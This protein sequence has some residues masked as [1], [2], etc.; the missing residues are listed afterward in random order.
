MRPL[1]RRTIVLAPLAAVFASGC[2]DTDALD[3]LPE[4]REGRVTGARAGGVIELDGREPVKLAGLEAPDA[5]EPYAQASRLIL[6]RLTLNRRV[7]LYFAGARTDASGM[8]LAQVEDAD[9]RRWIQ[10]ALL[11]AGAARVRTEPDACAG[12]AAMLA[13]EARARSAGRGVWRIPMYEVRLPT[14]FGW[15]DRGFML[16]EGRV[17]RVGEGRD[18]LYLD[19]NR[20]WRGELSL[21]AARPTLRA[22]RTA[23]LDLYDLEGRLIRARG[24]VAERRMALDHP[25]QIEPL[26]V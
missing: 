2:Q 20:D 23:G 15:N 1:D 26:T 13:R 24:V 6:Q 21:T 22:F 19:F 10:G 9:R 17:R 14:E 8:A 3:G 25:A 4:G 5:D 18:T 11:D 12:A 7:R 16:V